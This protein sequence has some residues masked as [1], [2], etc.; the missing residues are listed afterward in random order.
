MKP[1]VSVIVPTLNRP[2]LLSYAL[3]SV[4]GQHLDPAAVE[5]IVVNDGGPDVSAPI[6]AARDHGL[7]I[8]LI[9]LP[10]RGGLPAARNVGIAAARGDY[11]AFLD[12]D[13]VFLPAHLAVTLDALGTTGTDAAYTICLLRTTR[14]DPDDDVAPISGPPPPPFDGELLSVTNLIPVHSAVIRRPPET[15]RFDADL[16]ALEDW[17]MWLRLVHHGFRFVHVPQPTVVYHRIPGQ[18]SMSGAT[19]TKASTLAAYGQLTE[20]LWRRWPPPTARVAHFRLY[21]GVMYW[22]ALTALST[23]GELNELYFQRCVEQIAAV[24]HGQAPEDGLVQR[25]IQSIRSGTD[26]VYAA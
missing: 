14:V 8:R 5:A 6:A 24:W 18:A 2:H 12:D 22:H 7:A 11:L 17:D 13:D 1:L 15:A 3:R 10:R 21:V 25:I 26:G 23:R 20:S 16:P 4:A 19:V 9:N